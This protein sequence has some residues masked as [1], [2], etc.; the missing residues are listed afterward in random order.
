[1]RNV[2]GVGIFGLTIHLIK[3]VLSEIEC[4]SCICEEWVG[5]MHFPV[6]QTCT[7]WSHSH[8]D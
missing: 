5:N 4:Q 7:W 2:E 6:W 3:K 1:M 8:N